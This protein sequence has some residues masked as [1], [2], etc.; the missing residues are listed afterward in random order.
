MSSS[1]EIDVRQIRLS[2]NQ[3]LFREVNERVDKAS[4]AFSSDGPIT[5]VCECSNTN[6]A[7]QIELTHDDYE[8]IRSVPTWFAVTPGQKIP[9]IE[10]VV[11]QTER[12]AVVEKIEAGGRLAAATDP[13]RG[14]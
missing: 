3:V 8:R 10:D 5:F 6:C 13:R 14:R 11:E 1:P 9:D 2:R 12:Y 7:A 4:H